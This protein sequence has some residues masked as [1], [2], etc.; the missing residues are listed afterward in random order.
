MTP[1]HQGDA[2]V[3]LLNPDGTFFQPPRFLGLVLPHLAALAFSSA[4][5]SFVLPGMN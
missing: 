3:L 2:L 4:T 1:G 5:S